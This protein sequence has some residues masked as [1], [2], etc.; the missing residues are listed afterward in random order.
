MLIQSSKKDTISDFTKPIATTVNQ[1]HYLST[2]IN[3]D[4]TL[5]FSQ[6]SQPFLMLCKVEKNKTPETEKSNHIQLIKLYQSK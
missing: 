2:C 6:L 3:S 1:Y 4:F 5:L